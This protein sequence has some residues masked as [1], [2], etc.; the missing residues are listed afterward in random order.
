MFISAAFRP[1][2]ALYGQGTMF[3]LSLSTCSSCYEEGG[4]ETEADSLPRYATLLFARKKLDCGIY[5]SDR[6]VAANCLPRRVNVLYAIINSSDSVVPTNS[7]PLAD[8]HRVTEVEA[9][10]PV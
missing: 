8:I 2:S 1:Y 10:R 6:L 5:C 3:S 9:R 4:A 7:L